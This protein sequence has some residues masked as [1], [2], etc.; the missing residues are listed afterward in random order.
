VINIFETGLEIKMDY[1]TDNSKFQVIKIPGVLFGPDEIEQWFA[2]VIQAKPRFVEFKEVLPANSE[3]WAKILRLIG[4]TT[5]DHRKALNSEYKYIGV[6]TNP[7]ARMVIYFDILKN[8]TTEEKIH[9]PMY[10]QFNLTSFDAFVNQ[11]AVLPKDNTWPNWWWFTTN[12]ADWLI[13]K[14]TCEYIFKAETIETDFQIIRDYFQ[15]STDLLIDDGSVYSDYHP[16]YS[17]I[18]KNLVS[19]IFKKDIDTFGYTF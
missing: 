4:N 11:V 5:I 8:L 17:D 15:S 1:L 10:E 14:N 12:Q 16:R 19:V 13:G 9:F 6:V 18:S 3:P 2:N 7:W